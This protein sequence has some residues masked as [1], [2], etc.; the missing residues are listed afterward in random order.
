MEWIDNE[1]SLSQQ[2]SEAVFILG[3]AAPSK[4]KSKCFQAFALLVQKYSS[5]IKGMIFGH[6]HYDNFGKTNTLA[7]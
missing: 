3:H 5:S 2:N 1:L 4:M 7:L 6:A